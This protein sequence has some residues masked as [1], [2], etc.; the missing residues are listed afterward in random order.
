MSTTNP[1]SGTSIRLVTGLFTSGKRWIHRYGFAAMLAAGMTLG[2]K[3]QAQTTIYN[4]NFNTLANGGARNASGQYSTGSAP[5]TIYYFNTSGLSTS[6]ISTPAATGNFS[7]DYVQANFNSPSGNKNDLM[8][9]FTSQTLVSV[10]DSITVQFDFR[11]PSGTGY[12]S[13]PVGGQDRNPEFG[14]Y[15]GTVLTGDSTTAPAVV[16]GY[17]INITSTGA[18]SN[19]DTV[20]GASSTGAF[21]SD[22]AIGAPVNIGTTFDGDFTENFKFVLTKT[23]A[24]STELQLFLNGSTTATLAVTDASSTNFTYDEFDLRARDTA[25]IDNFSIT[26]NIASVPEPSTAGI[27]LFTAVVL[28]GFQS[29]RRKLV[30]C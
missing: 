3:V 30:L 1:P 19:A 26:D 4:D 13:T 20:A 23:G 11:Y 12:D 10:G 29:V 9:P 5:A 18:S 2:G 17:D 15:N 16:T 22:A 27:L 21:F 25:Q 8:S 24:T 7:G 14:F 28:V 6:A